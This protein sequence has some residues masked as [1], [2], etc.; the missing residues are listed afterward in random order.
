MV[1]HFRFLYWYGKGVSM[2]SSAQTE[3]V[4]PDG[5]KAAAMIS[6]DLDAESGLLHSD[7]ATATYLDVLA[8]LAYEPRAGV[9]RLLKVLQRKGFPATFFTPGFTAERWPESVL[10]V[11][12]AGHEI[13]HHGYLHEY[14][15]GADEATEEGYLQRGFDALERIVGVRPTGYRAPGFQMNFGTPGLLAKHGFTYDSSLQD[16]DVPYRLMSADE[17]N[18]PS[19]IEIPVQWALDDFAHYMF[20][21]GLKPY[22]TIADPARVLN[23]WALELEA[24]VAEGGVFTLTLHPYLSGRASRARALET[25]LEVMQSIHGLWVATGAQI[26]EYAATQPTQPVFHRPVCLP[27]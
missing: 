10:S 23:M 7:P 27:E 26:A 17:P 14:V 18:A 13:G 1:R 24:L 5:Y 9:A 11:R 21:P 16:S 15:H 25:L 3:F 12:D 8:Q 22:T 19:L 2:T 20:L 6:I 4:W